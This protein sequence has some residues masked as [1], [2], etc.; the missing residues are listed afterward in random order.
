M[1]DTERLKC[2]SKS[3]YSLI[4]HSKPKITISLVGQKGGVTTPYTTGDRI[5]GTAVILV[6]YDT[7][8][9]E[10]EISFK[11]EARVL[12][13]RRACPGTSGAGYR[14]LNIRQSVEHFEDLRN[15]VLKAG[16]PYEFTFLFMVPERL[17]PHICQHQF[18][19]CHIGKYHAMLPPTIGKQPC[20][21]DENRSS[22][23]M[24]LEMTKVFYTIE[25]RILD[26]CPTSNPQ[27][28]ILANSIKVI[29]VVPTVQEDATLDLADQTYFCARKENKVKRN[30]LQPSIGRMVASCAQPKAIQ[31]LISNSEG[32]ERVASIATLKLEFHP[33]GDEKPPDLHSI[34]CKLRISTFYSVFPWQDFPYRFGTLPLS[35]AGQGLKTS[36]LPVCKMRVATQQWQKHSKP[37][38]DDRFEFSLCSDNPSASLAGATYYTAAIV[39]PLRLPNSKS[40]V[41]TFHSCL[42]SRTYSLDMSLSYNSPGMSIHASSISLNVPIQMTTRRNATQLPSL[43]SHFD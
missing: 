20:N 11:G 22:E 34:V 4:R 26:K 42:I 32:K 19:N 8:F 31:L 29:R 30:F 1:T 12:V 18:R 35:R 33:A 37:S 7:P 41:P 28:R 39:I 40:F 25:V 36:V 3:L 17:S 38:N 9:N 21:E 6:D 15:C 43:F 5:E 16:H 2:R 27:I 14:F 24:T 10:I 23:D 13:E